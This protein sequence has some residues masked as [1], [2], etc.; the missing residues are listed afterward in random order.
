MKRS[1]TAIRFQIRLQYF[2]ALMHHLIGRG[3]VN[4]HRVCCAQFLRRKWFELGARGAH[5]TQS[6]D[7][8]RARQ[9]ECEG[10]DAHALERRG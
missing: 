3:L 1:L 7:G 9:V 4:A 6:H 10:Q 8:R 2:Q 5:V